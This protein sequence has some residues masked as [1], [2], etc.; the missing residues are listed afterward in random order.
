MEMAGYDL[1]GTGGVWVAQRVPDDQ[2][3][4]AQTNSASAMC[5]PMR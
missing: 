4:V 3:F 2:F 1:N 5:A